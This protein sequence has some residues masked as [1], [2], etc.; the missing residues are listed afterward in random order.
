M[1]ELRYERKYLLSVGDY[2]TVSSEIMI[3]PAG[4][5][6][7][8]PD[9]HIRNI[10]F[11]T[12]ELAALNTN[13]YGVAERAKHRVRWYGDTVLPQGKARWETKQKFNTLGAKIVED[14]HI[15]SGATL[16]SIADEVNTR[17]CK[18]QP[19]VPTL[20]NTYERSYF[21]TPDN[22]FR[23]TVD[24]DMDFLP[25]FNGNKSS[26][27]PFTISN[28]VVELKYDQE[29]DDEANEILKYIPF[30]QTKNS[31]YVTGMLMGA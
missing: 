30:R 27:R 3:H 2:R 9:R 29:W 28:I 19:L 22:K 10:Y 25:V 23:M 8:H 21:V 17:F 5:R 7:Q 14:M 15:E 31:K 13:L 12:V 4:F 24:R 16:A 18:M 1:K 6:I 11:D 20:M 26:T